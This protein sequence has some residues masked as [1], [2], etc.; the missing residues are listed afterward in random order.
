MALYVIIA[1][2]VT[3]LLWSGVTRIGFYSLIRA[4]LPS[5]L[6]K[7]GV[8]V[9]L[10]KAKNAVQEELISGSRALPHQ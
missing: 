4:S 2:K 8:S 6:P 5:E 9:T 3:L 1:S 7:C 10:I